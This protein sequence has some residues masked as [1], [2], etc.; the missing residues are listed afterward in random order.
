MTH[1]HHAHDHSHDH[2]DHHH[3]DHD[4][5]DHGHSGSDSP[6]MSLED[7]L[8][9]LLTH[10][11]DHNNSHMETYKSWAQKADDGNIN[12]VADLLRQTA[13]TSAGITKALEEALKHL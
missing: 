9:T 1:H 5:H 7:K 8:K 3:H 2:E 6:A 13:D 4:H 10:W 11:I 12:A